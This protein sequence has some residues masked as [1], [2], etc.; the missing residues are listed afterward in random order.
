MY[1]LRYRWK[2]RPHR[3]CHWT[4]GNNTAP[5]CHFS[6]IQLSKLHFTTFRPLKVAA[7]FAS[8]PIMQLLASKSCINFSQCSLNVTWHPFPKR[9]TNGNFVICWRCPFWTLYVKSLCN[10]WRQCR[11]ENSSTWSWG[12]LRIFLILA[13]YPHQLRN[14]SWSPKLLSDL[15]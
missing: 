11:V 4:F 15:K 6:W 2:A 12:V 5:L 3:T 14:V 13:T 9:T 10:F 8:P 7:T 1:Q